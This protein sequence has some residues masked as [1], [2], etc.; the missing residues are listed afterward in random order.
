MPESFEDLEATYG[1]HAPF[2][3]HKRGDYITYTTAEGLPGAGV[4]IWIRAAFQEI[5]L[6][7]IVIPDAPGAFLDFVMPGDVITSTQEGQ[8]STLVRCVW[9]GAVHQADQV[10]QCPLKP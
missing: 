7:Y 10:N 4:I 1:S 6:K 5:P 3:E 8:E 9:C 2:S